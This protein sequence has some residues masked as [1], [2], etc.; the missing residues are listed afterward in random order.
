MKPQPAA[1]RQGHTRRRSGSRNCSGC[2]ALL[3]RWK[4]F[5]VRSGLLR[6][7]SGWCQKKQNSSGGKDRLG[8]VYPANEAIAICAAYSTT[9]AL[10]VIRYARKS[11]APGI[12]AVAHGI[13]GA[14]TDEGCSHRARQ[15]DRTGMAWAMMQAAERG[16]RYKEP[17]RTDGLNEIAP[18]VWR[19]A[20]DG[21][22]GRTARNARAGRSGDQD[23]PLWSHSI[24]ECGRTFDRDLIRW[25]ALWPAVM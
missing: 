4:A 2:P 23:N 11:T 13:A 14:A 17:A 24:V 19:N 6:P 18:D 20:L 8:S 5:S 15:Q 1:R 22:E 10:A 12:E 3:T 16:E 25:R 7:G 9:G 21:W